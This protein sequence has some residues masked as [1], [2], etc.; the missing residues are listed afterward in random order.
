MMWNQNIAGNIQNQWTMP[1]K[2]DAEGL[3]N[4]KMLLKMCSSTWRK[5]LAG[6][7]KPLGWTCCTLA[8]TVPHKAWCTHLFCHVFVFTVRAGNIFVFTWKNQLFKIFITVVAFIFINWHIKPLK[9]LGGYIKNNNLII[10]L[11]C[12]LSIAV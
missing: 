6:S 7:W 3:K 5:K 4:L 12:F 2:P 11:F 1:K 10:S 9:I 8:D